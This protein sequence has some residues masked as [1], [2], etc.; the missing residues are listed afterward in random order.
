MD[1]QIK[2]GIIINIVC[3]LAVVFA[4]IIRKFTVNFH[5]N[6]FETTIINLPGLAKSTKEKNT[7][8]SFWPLSHIILYIILGI[9]APDYWYLW[10]IIGIFW[11]IIEFIFGK[12]SKTSGKNNTQYGDKWLNYR[13][14]DI[15]F[16]LFGLLIG[17]SISK[18]I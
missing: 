8:Y 3:F 10:I 2:I 16:N 7:G 13:F 5:N 18:L 14:S 12:L 15:F 9:V 17:V 4:F 1:R 6:I 11:E